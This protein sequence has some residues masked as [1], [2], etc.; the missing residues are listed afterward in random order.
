MS[1]NVMLVPAGK[2]SG[3]F[4]ASLGLV[5]ALNDNG[6]KAALFTP[7]YSCCRKEC[8]N[9]SLN[10]CCAAKKLSEGNKSEV[11]E[12]IVA[13]YNALNDANKYDVIVIEGVTD[14]PFNVNEINAEICHAFDA[15]IISVVSGKC[16]C[17]KSAI[18][19][20]LLYFGNAGKNQHLGTI[21]LNDKA[22]RDAKGNKKLVLS[23]CDKCGAACAVKNEDEVLTDFIANVNFDVAYY[24]PRAKDIAQFIDAKIASG[25]ENVRSYKVALSNETA[26]EKAVLVTDTVPVKTDAKTVILT[27]GVTGSVEGATVITTEKPLWSVAQALAEFPAQLRDDEEQKKLIEEKSSKDFDAKAIDLIKNLEEKT[28]PLMSPAAFRSKLTALARA[29][30]KKIALPEGD[31]P[32]TVCAAA[33]VAEQNIAVPVLFGKKDKILEVAKA[34][35][36]TLGENVEFVDPD[37][38]REKY[39]DRLVELRKAKGVTPEQALEMLQ[40]NVFLAT[41]MIDSKELDGLVSGAVHTTANTIRPAL[42]ILKTAPGAKLVSA[43]FFMLMD[44]QVYVYGDCALNINPTA[45][46]IS[47]IAIQSADTAKAFGIDPRVAMIT[48]STINSGKGAD[49]DMM[50]EATALVRSKRPDIAVDGPLQY[51]AAVMPDV[52]AQKAPGSPVA[53]K[54][55]VFIFPN[56]STGNTVYKA[57]QRS[58][59]LVSIGPMLQGMKR[60][61]NDLS[62]GALVDDIIYTVAVTAIQATQVKD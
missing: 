62:R 56:L 40:D 58:A 2:T 32:R 44:E 36:V 23:G 20:T 37:A 18:D 50:K 27:D 33:K 59:K 28:T 10:K 39:V 24:A 41:M 48:Y 8:S 1:R 13:N 42:Q 22:P 15:N 12:A 19:A 26:K 61:V 29:A 30:H 57:V 46:E 17:A 54:A 34:Q 3:I 60:P 25:D 49:V 6:V 52:A 4:T 53:G 51:D 35:G 31:E 9:T 11:I 47:E 5:K 43:I 45:E 55:T 38:V 21:L 16:K 7:F 14:A